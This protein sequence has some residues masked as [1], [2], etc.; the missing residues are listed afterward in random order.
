MTKAPVGGDK[1]GSNLTDRAKMGEAFGP[2]GRHWIP[3]GRARATTFYFASQPANAGLLHPSPE[4]GGA[5][6]SGLPPY[7]TTPPALSFW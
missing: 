1:T 7:T 6:P 5:G 2:Y 3:I 4:P